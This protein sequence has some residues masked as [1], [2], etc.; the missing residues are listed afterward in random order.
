MAGG[1]H[2]SHTWLQLADTFHVLRHNGRGRYSTMIDNTLQKGGDNLDRSEAQLM[3]KRQNKHDRLM[4][5]I[6]HLEKEIVRLES[7]SQIY[8]NGICQ[9]G[10]EKVGETIPPLDVSLDQA[11][12][13]LLLMTGRIETARIGLE[14]ALF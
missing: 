3:A 4:D 9:T 10:D 12:A 1:L 8:G 13:T 2:N 5:A 7:L 11:A 14:T 6:G